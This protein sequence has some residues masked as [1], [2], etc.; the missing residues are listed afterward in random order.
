MCTRSST[1]YVPLLPEYVTTGFVRS[2]EMS[3]SVADTVSPPFLADAPVTD[4]PSPSAVTVTGAGHA[5]SAD[6]GSVHV[7]V[8]VTSVL[9]HP[10]SLAAGARAAAIDG[11]GR[12]S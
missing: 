11:R 8:M 10:A 1:P 6:S 7:N 4:C 9:L 2:I 3:P 5:T 12:S